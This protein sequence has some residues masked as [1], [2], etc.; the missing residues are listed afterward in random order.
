MKIYNKLQ[1]KWTQNSH[2]SDSIK[3]L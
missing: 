1:Q 2:V 3:I